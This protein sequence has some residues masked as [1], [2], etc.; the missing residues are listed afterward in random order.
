MVAMRVR[1][2]A[3]GNPGDVKPVG[4]GLC[5]LRIHSGP[6]Y[7][8][9]FTQRGDTLIVLLCGG[10]KGSQARDITIARSLA[11]ELEL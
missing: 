3:F 4:G 5:E 9:Y 1:R 10:D 8:V 7:R 11:R 2:L 6:G